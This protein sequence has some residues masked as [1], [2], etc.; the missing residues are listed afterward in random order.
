MWL[1]SPGRWP[2]PGCTSGP[3]PSPVRLRR[4]ARSVTAPFL[5]ARALPRVAAALADAGLY[6]QAE[7][8]AR[9]TTD[10]DQQANALAGVAESLARAGDTHSAIRLA[11]AACTAGQW[12]TEIMGNG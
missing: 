4:P 8:A 12:T 7:A 5:Q 6:Q 11:A 3:L 2:A 1:R 10:P 9:S